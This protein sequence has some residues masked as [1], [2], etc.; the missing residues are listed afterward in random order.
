MESNHRSYYIKDKKKVSKIQIQ[1][2]SKRCYFCDIFAA[3]SLFWKE[4]KKALTETGKF[5][6]IK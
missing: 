5:D 6:I 3:T 1:N 2:L 4:P